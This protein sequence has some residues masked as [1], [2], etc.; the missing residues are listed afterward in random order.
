MIEPIEVIIEGDKVTISSVE[1]TSQGAMSTGLNAYQR[2]NANIACYITNGAFI[3]GG[4]RNSDGLNPIV[5]IKGEKTI[6]GFKYF[7]FGAKAVKKSDKIKLKLNCKLINPTHLT[8]LVALPENAN[9]VEKRIEIASV[10]LMPSSTGNDF[11]DIEIPISDLNKNEQ[12][13]KIAGLEGKLAVFISLSGEKK[14]LFQLK[15]L[16]FVKCNNLTPNPLQ[17]INI[18]TPK[19]GSVTTTSSK[20]RYKESVKVSVVPDEGFK[21]ASIQVI[22]KMNKAVDIQANSIAP[23]AAESYN[24]FMPNSEVSIQAEFYQVID[25]NLK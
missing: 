18:E 23:Y 24:F 8:V 7:N 17:I 20:S 1:M 2:Y 21:F 19:N 6:I 15:E 3:D 16:E 4:Q 9:S 22:D 25:G 5:G 14:E 12:L 10:K 11:R 13:K